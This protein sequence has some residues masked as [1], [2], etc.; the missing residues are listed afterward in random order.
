MATKG[1]FNK[2]LS[3][4]ENKLTGRPSKL[5]KAK[6]KEMCN[7]MRMG[8][9]VESAALAIGL[10]KQNFYYHLKK[11]NKDIDAG[12]YMT[13]SAILVRELHKAAA[14]AELRDLQRIDQAGLG[15][16]RA[17]AWK[18]ERRQAAKWGTKS[19]LKLEKEKPGFSDSESLHAEMAKLIHAHEPQEGE[20]G[21]QSANEE[22][23]NETIEADYR[24][25]G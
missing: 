25:F 14:Q 13:I 19:A 23:G 16:W 1:K 21:T 22:T 20:D 9:Y 18:L 8:S 15:D 4:V 10:D 3:I 17:A 7:F 11:G 5:T 24:D 12:S 6:I 2:K